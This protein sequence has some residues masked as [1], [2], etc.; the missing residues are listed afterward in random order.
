MRLLRRRLYPLMCAALVLA[1]LRPAL[2]LE[3]T[4]TAALVAQAAASYP[5]CSL[6]HP[7]GTCFFLHCT[8][9]GCKI[10]TSLRFSHFIPDLVVSSFHDDASHPWPEIGVPLAA[11]TRASMSTLMTALIGS[12]SAG[13]LSRGDR[14][15]QQRRF[16]DTDAIGHPAAWMGTCPSAATSFM[17]YFQSLADALVWRGFLPTELIYPAST[18]PGIREVGVWP[19]NSWGNV[20]PR[21]GELIQHHPVKNAAV[22][23]Q[24]VADIVT[25][26]SP[27]VYFPL[28][29]GG[30]SVRAGQ[31]VWNPPPAME[32]SMMGGMWQMSAPGMTG[33]HVFGA[34]ELTAA[35]YG[36]LQTSS[37]GSYA[38]TLWRPYACCRIRGAFLFHIQTGAW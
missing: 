33:C 15:D 38:Y 12:D 19:R 26:A 16:R 10:R 1:P 31:I 5:F 25:R 32:G 20:H 37:T 21:T 6:W 24:R 36:D 28:R 35:S 8:F 2:A 29:S 4:N 13:T 22:L 9:F 14:T 7:S 27:H 30:T 3:A 34:P 17:P 18:I 11:G 23:S